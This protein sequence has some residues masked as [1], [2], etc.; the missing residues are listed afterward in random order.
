MQT[1]AL[2]TAR[3]CDEILGKMPQCLL[4]QCSSPEVYGICPSD[5]KVTENTPLCPNNPYAVGKAAADLYVLERVQSAGLR[6]FLTRAFSH[7]GPRRRRNFSISSDAYQI[8]KILKGKQEPV[9]RIGNMTSQRIVADVRDVVDV[10]YKLMMKFSAGS[11]PAGEVYHIAGN[12]L[13]P[14]QWYL[15]KMLDLYDLTER[16]NLSVD[17]SLFRKVDIPIQIPDDTKVREL[18]GWKPAIPI[19]QTLRDLVDYWLEED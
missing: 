3:I 17:P 15:D 2:G 4:M 10:Y 18:L 14:M 19:E 1:N 12:D 5:A 8:A 6:A 11:I 7:T 13:H 9:I 16:V